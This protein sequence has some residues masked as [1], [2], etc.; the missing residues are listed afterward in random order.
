MIWLQKIFEHNKFNIYT[1]LDPIWITKNTRYLYVTK[2]LTIYQAYKKLRLCCFFFLHF[3]PTAVKINITQWKSLMYFY[4]TLFCFKYIV[5]YTPW[6]WS[7][8]VKTCRRNY[9]L[10][11]LCM[12]HLQMFVFFKKSII[13]KHEQIIWSYETYWTKT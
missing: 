1:G 9:K 3:M 11:S 6:W 12:C 2:K 5:V 10:L 4:H 8:A 13:S 7:V